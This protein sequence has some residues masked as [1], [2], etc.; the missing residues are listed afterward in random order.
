MMK[1]I[2]LTL[3]AL[4][5]ILVATFLTLYNENP[6]IGVYVYDMSDFYM[7]N[8]IDHLSDELEGIGDIYI[9][10]AKNSQILQNEAI[11]K[12]IDKMDI[13]VVNPV[14]RL[15]SY[16]LIKL[17]KSKNKTIIFIN[18]EPLATDLETYEKAYYIGSKAIQSAKY[19]AELIAELYGNN[20][21]ELNEVD[22]NNDNKIQ[23]VIFKGQ[24]G[25]QDAEDRTEYLQKFLIESGYDIDIVD[26]KTA[27]WNKQNSKRIMGEMLI[28]QTY[29]EVIACNN[30][31]MALGVVEA[32]DEFNSSNN[33]N[34]KI[35]I[36]GV[37]GMKEAISAIKE[38]KM[39]GT[40]LNDSKLQAN[41]VFN[42]LQ[43]ELNNSSQVKNPKYIWIDYT[44]LN[45]KI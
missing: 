9:H 33:S 4:M 12:Q 7:I 13:L 2:F 43:D 36:I 28:E 16:A 25:H 41:A 29:V 6:K 42:L 35:N 19:Q 11:L 20:P 32:I 30:D 44:R 24:R 45:N 8:Y 22:E 40:V 17:A 23:I 34:I 1:K 14:D 21:N 5:L 3:F 10:D 18:R 15:S 27:D 37:D 38:G 26:I 31:Y 39:Y